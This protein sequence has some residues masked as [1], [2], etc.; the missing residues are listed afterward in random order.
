MKLFFHMLFFCLVIFNSPDS[1]SQISVD[2]SISDIKICF[3][4]K[5]KK[6]GYTMDLNDIKIPVNAK[7]FATYKISKFTGSL[8]IESSTEGR[9]T[10][11]AGIIHAN[12]QSYNILYDALLL[13]SKELSNQPY[14]LP[15]PGY[16]ATSAWPVN[17]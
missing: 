4:N 15:T 1:Y 17:G 12:S 14:L 2:A 6:D 7:E 13:C 11:E 16:A 10:R 8:W 3:A 9:P 5:I